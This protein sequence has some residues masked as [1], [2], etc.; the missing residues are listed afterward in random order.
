FPAMGI[1]AI[2]LLAEPFRALGTFSGLLDQ[3]SFLFVIFAIYRGFIGILYIIF[4][5]ASVKAYQNR[6]LGPLLGVGFGL[7]VL[8]L[9]V[10]LE[11]LARAKL[12]SLFG[13][14][15]EL[16]G[17]FIAS[18]GLYFWLQFI[19]LLQ[20]SLESYSQHRLDAGLFSAWL[21]I[22]SYVLYF[23]GFIAAFN[24]LGLDGNTLAFVTGGLSVG[25]GFSLRS[26]LANFLSGII[27]LFERSLKPGDIIEFNGEMVVVQKL[28]IRS[29]TVRNYKGVDMIIPNE[30]LLTNTVV[31]YSGAGESL[32]YDI[33][34]GVAY[35][36]E[37]HVAIESILTIAN[38]HIKVLDIPPPQCIITG[39]GESSV[40]LELRIWLKQ[41][42]PIVKTEILMTVYQD[43]KNKGIEIPFPQQDIYVKGVSGELL[44]QA[45]MG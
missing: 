41:I 22:I 15:I 36:T 42:D 27:L 10:N 39:F 17:L 21:T 28:R 29:T 12:F 44:A 14:D 18:L 34:V 3:C 40:D 2:R 26:V 9:V 4:S 37:L 11:S 19:A 32:R 38:N 45:K 13:N 33:P 24:V 16:G 20:Q 5:D 30:N 8:S 25:I 43:F 23:L 35:G 1:L 6:L 31:S 7:Y